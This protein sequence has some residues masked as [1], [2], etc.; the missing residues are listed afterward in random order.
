MERV[1]T[2][3]GIKT[4]NLYDIFA[5][6]VPGVYFLIGLYVGTHPTKILDLFFTREV[7]IPVGLPLLL[8]V[9]AVAFVIGQ[10]LQLG[11]GVYDDDHG[12]DAL[13]RR[14]RG[15]DV[16]CRYNISEVEDRFWEMC[17]QEFDLSDEFESHETLFNLLLSYVEASGRSRALRLQ[18]LYLFVRGVFVAS[19]YLTLLYATLVI[20]L[21]FDYPLGPLAAVIRSIEVNFLYAVLAMALTKLTDRSRAGLEEDWIEY[22][23]VESYLEMLDNREEKILSYAK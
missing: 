7:V 19:T 17:R 14:I 13:M 11:G 21:L 3:Q 1:V 20:V 23:V 5:N 18:A 16:S 4:I 2:N 12:F 22:T 6:I 10:L 9:V 8:L 15:E